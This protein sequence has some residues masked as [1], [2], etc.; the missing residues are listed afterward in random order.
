MASSFAL[1]S[2]A[3]VV[4]AMVV[5]LLAAM[6]GQAETRKYQFDVSIFVSLFMHASRSRQ[7]WPQQVW[8]VNRVAMLV[9]D[10]LRAYIYIYAS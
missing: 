5:V 7:S 8:Q 10:V 2:S 3:S 4:V 6:G 1:R 9:S